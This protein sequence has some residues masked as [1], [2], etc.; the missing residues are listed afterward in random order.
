[1]ANEGYQVELW[2]DFRLFE[3]NSE[4]PKGKIRKNH[5]IHRNQYKKLFQSWLWR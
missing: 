5:S 2:A 1:M 3:F 4:G